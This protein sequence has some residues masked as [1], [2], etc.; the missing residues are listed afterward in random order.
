MQI[1]E[2]SKGWDGM[3]Y[4]HMGYWVFCF[5]SFL[6]THYGVKRLGR[7]HAGYTRGKVIEDG[8]IDCW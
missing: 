1:T 2:L 3:G 4:K 6:Y 7:L 8:G 5:L